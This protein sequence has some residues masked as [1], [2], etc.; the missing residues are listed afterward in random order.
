MNTEKC[1]TDVQAPGVTGDLMES[2]VRGVRWAVGRLQGEKRGGSPGVEL[3]THVTL[4]RSL[5]E[6]ERGVNGR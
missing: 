6:G 4:W 1:L 5:T 3:M 2:C